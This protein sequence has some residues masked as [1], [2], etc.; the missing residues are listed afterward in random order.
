[1]LTHIVACVYSDLPLRLNQQKV[2]RPS[3]AVF[4]GHC[5]GPNGDVLD[6]PSGHR[7]WPDLPAMQS[8]GARN[9]TIP[10]QNSGPCARLSGASL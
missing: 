2:A 1:L 4:C 10:L 7:I 5:A 9:P 8:V 3:P 6:V